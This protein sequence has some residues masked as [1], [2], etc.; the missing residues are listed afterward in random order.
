MGAAAGTQQPTR[1]RAAVSGV[2]SEVNIVSVDAYAL[3]TD[4][5]ATPART[6]L[7]LEEVKRAAKVEPGILA[8]FLAVAENGVDPPPTLDDP[9]GDH[10]RGPA[11]SFEGK[12]LQDWQRGGLGIAHY[13]SGSLE[14]I[15]ELFG[16]PDI[17]EYQQTWLYDRVLRDPATRE[18][19]ARWARALVERPDFLRWSITYW[20]EHYWAKTSGEVPQRLANARIRNSRPALAAKVA[21]LPWQEQVARYET[22][23]GGKRGVE[24]GNM[25]RRAV[26]VW[27]AYR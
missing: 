5:I 10:W 20:L 13:D 12:R 18:A 23:V 22:F 16:A 25:I 4:I 7:T 24:R 17:T 8:L 27:E 11:G 3:I 14:R 1:G 6:C 19:W 9:A 21:S 26:A 15:Y 2:T